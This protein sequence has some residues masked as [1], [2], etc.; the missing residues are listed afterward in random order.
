M[1]HIFTGLFNTFTF[2]KLGHSYIDMQSRLFSVFMTLTISPPLIQQLQPR[3]LHFRNLYESREAKAKIYSW[4]A[5]VVS[6]ILPEIP[7]SIIAGS[8][9]FNCWYWGIGFPRDSFTSGFTYIMILLF[10]LYY[11]GFGQFIA[12]LSPNELFAS[13]IVPAFFTFV[14][15]FCGVVVPYSG[16]PSFW[17]AW[18]YWLTPFH[19]L[20]E[21]FLGVLVHD[22]PVQC[23]AREEARFTPPPGSTCQNYTSAYTAEAGGYV[24]DSGDGMCSF[25]AYATGDQFVRLLLLL[26]VIRTDIMTTGLQLQRVLFL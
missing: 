3:F 14:V 22:Q 7:Y 15:S 16:L 21:A 10:E 18:M 23:V 8:I 17:K 26:R 12:A 6:A 2:W 24:T 5:F 20:L 9:Y 13:L 1:L 11:I 25:C 4:P 19:Y